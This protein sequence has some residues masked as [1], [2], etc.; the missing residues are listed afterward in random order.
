MWVVVTLYT[1]R[2]LLED[3]GVILFHKRKNACEV[4]ISMVRDDIGTDRD[5]YYSDRELIETLFND[6][7]EGKTNCF[8]YVMKC[9]LR[10]INAI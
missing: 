10:E 1:A 8:D 7:R 4:L 5:G 6:I 3:V 2:G 9:E